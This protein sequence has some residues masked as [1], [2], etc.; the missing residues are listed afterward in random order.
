MIE[1]GEYTNTNYCSYKNIDAIR[2]A[3]KGFPE[4]EI[5]QHTND[6]RE[7]TYA[8]VAKNFD[9]EYLDFTNVSDE[10]QHA[11]FSL[12]GKYYS[13]Y[14]NIKNVK[15]AEDLPFTQIFSLSEILRQEMEKRDV[16]IVSSFSVGKNEN[17]PP[18][19]TITSYSRN[20]ILASICSMDIYSETR[21][22][23]KKYGSSFNV[24]SEVSP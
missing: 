20:D 17:T 15:E 8:F 21:E 10:D 12:Y 3:L 2:N 13:A 11:F 9:A 7:T 14:S 24:P 6:K 23:I 22:A 4:I 19:S 5:I 16:L 18:F 1:T